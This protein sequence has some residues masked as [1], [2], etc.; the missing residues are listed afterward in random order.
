VDDDFGNAV[1]GSPQSRNRLENRR[2]KDDKMPGEMWKTVEAN[3]EKIRVI[4]T[5]GGSGKEG[6]GKETR[7]ERGK[8]EA[9]RRKNSRSKEGSRRMRNMG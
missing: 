7:R 8:E 2:G 5:E 1:V 6:S 3:A 9:K 4:E